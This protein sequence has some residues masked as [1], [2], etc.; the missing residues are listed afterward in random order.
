MRPATSRAVRA[1]AGAPPPSGPGRPARHRAT[2]LGAHEE[3]LVAGVDL[4]RARATVS[5]HP[6][7]VRLDGHA[8]G[9]PPLRRATVRPPQDDV[10]V[11]GPRGLQLLGGLP[12]GPVGVGVLGALEE[13]QRQMLTTASSATS[14][15]PICRPRR[16]PARRGVV[17]RGSQSVPE[18]VH[19]LHHAPAELAPQVVH[20]GVDRA[21]F[22]APREGALEQLLAAED[23]PRAPRQHLEQRGLPAGQGHLAL[24]HDGGAA[25][26][27]E[28]AT[29]TRSRA[30]C[31]W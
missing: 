31:S 10:E 14:T 16:T 6:V 8:R 1:V 24:V 20:V 4:A 27:L 30:A 5:D 26:D 3:V 18:A 17:T 28:R 7:E 15:R 12:E 19:R 21:R 2:L 23:L 9:G 22:R 13:D 29:R 25:L 11:A